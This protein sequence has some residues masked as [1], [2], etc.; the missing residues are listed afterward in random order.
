MATVWTWTSSSMSMILKR[1]TL[2]R[3]CQCS[4][5]HVMARFHVAM[6]TRVPGGPPLS[7][8]A[9]T[10]AWTAVTHRT[11]TVRQA[12]SAH[13]DP[14][15]ARHAWRRPCWT[16]AASWRKR[17]MAVVSRTWAA[18]TA[19]WQAPTPHYPVPTASIVP[20][21]GAPIRQL[22]L[23]CPHPSHRRPPICSTYGSRWP[24]P[25]GRSGSWRSR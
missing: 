3:R 12:F 5:G 9:P 20:R 24:S 1:A 14:T 25:C 13:S 4:D 23:A 8:S 17:R 18:C 16:L 19:A 21:E 2:L 10:P 7:R 22:A 11:P 6:D 15:S